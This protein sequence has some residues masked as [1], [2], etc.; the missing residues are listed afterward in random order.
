[1]SH[2]SIRIRIPLSVYKKYK[3][4]CVENELSLPKQTTSLIKCFI[5]IDETNKK[6]TDH[7]KK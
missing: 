3:H 2:V 4:I 1:M 5:E 7:L 6:L